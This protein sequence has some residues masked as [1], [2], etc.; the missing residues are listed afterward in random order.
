MNRIM[1]TASNTFVMMKRNFLH[2][3]RNL[4]SIMMTIMLPIL[5]LFVLVYVFGGAIGEG[6][7][8]LAYLQYIVPGMVAMQV[9]F[10]S[11]MTSVSV[12]DD[13]SKGIIDRFRAMNISSLAVLTGQLFAAV[14][15]NA[16]G[17]VVMLITAL[18]IGFKPTANFIEWIAVI[19][20][21]VL[22]VSSISWISIMLGLLANSPESASGTNMFLQFIPYISSAFLVTSTMPGWLKVFADNQPFTPIVDTIRALF[23]GYDVGNSGWIAIAWC[24]G[25][26]VICFAVSMYL[27]RNKT[28]N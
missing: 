26:T 11:Y 18:L 8:R 14:L 19:G 6:G 15:R 16:L 12:C 5:V 23:L 22:F 1:H 28:S 25:I 10:C 17:I 27:Y 2:T 4:E 3:F 24:V 13:M 20:M 9:V 7:D 21:M